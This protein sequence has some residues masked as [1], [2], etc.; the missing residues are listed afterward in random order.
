MGQPRTKG[1]RTRDF[2]FGSPVYLCRIKA[3]CHV[4]SLHVARLAIF[5]FAEKRYTVVVLYVSPGRKI[6]D[7]KFGLLGESG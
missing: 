5:H 3:V 4:T 2:T 1:S 6:V 7:G